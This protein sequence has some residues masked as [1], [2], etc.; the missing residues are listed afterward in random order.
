MDEEMNE[1]KTEGVVFPELIDID[2][3]GKYCIEV[4][5]FRVNLRCSDN[6]RVDSETRYDF[7]GSSRCLAVDSDETGEIS[8]LFDS[9]SL[10]KEDKNQDLYNWN[11]SFRLSIWLKNQLGIP[12][13]NWVSETD[14]KEGLYQSFN[15]RSELLESFEDYDYPKKLDDVQIMTTKSGMW[16][17]VIYGASREHDDYYFSLNSDL[18]AIVAINASPCWSR[19]PET[20]T[21]TRE[22]VTA[23]LDKLI[24]AVEIIKVGSVPDEELPPLGFY[25]AKREEKEIDSEGRV[26]EEEKPEPII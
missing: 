18:V 24:E 1:I 22:Y 5:G 4:N 23:F 15:N 9:L 8:P 19:Y 12:V 21:E 13:K 6:A 25:P 26:V 3:W 16:G 20:A 7:S 14:I 10:V 2:H 11:F 17:H